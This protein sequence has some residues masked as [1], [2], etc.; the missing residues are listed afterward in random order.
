M[1]DQLERKRLGLVILHHL[2]EPHARRIPPLARPAVA[3]GD[4]IRHAHAALE[5]PGG[6]L[7]RGVERLDP[8]A[9]G[10][11]RPLGADLHGEAELGPGAGADLLGV[12]DGLEQ[13]DRRRPAGKG[14]RAPARSDGLAPGGHD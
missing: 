2:H 7:D 4:E 9:P 11:A 10:T 14:R 1:R 8:V 13:G 12:L 5:L 3:L 6:R